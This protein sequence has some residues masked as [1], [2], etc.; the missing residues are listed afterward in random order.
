MST[1]AAPAALAGWLADAALKA[2][3]NWGAELERMRALA[4]LPFPPLKAPPFH[5][6]PAGWEPIWWPINTAQQEAINC[7]AEL[8]LFGGESGG[9][10]TSFLAANAMQEYKNPYL[11]ALVLRTTRNG[12]GRVVRANAAHVRAAGGALAPAQQV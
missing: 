3:I 6:H 4:P 1:Q 10:E 7:R 11:N 9:G 2:H 8:L 12:D 5:L